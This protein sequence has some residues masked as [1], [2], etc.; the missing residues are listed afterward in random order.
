MYVLSCKYYVRMYVSIMYVCM[1]YVFMCYTCM[2][3][4]IYV[5]IYGRIMYVCI[6]VLCVYVCIHVL[7]MYVCMFVCMYVLCMYVGGMV[8]KTAGNV[9]SLRS[10]MFDTKRIKTAVTPILRK[11]NYIAVNTSLSLCITCNSVY[12]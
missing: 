2:Y 6:Y 7:C 10:P 5:R 11:L 9:Q 1:Y 3:V 8:R 4:C 12:R